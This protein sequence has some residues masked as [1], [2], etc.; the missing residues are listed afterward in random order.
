MNQELEA[1]RQ[2][3]H[4]MMSALENHSYTNEEGRAQLEAGIQACIKEE[5]AI[6]EKY[7]VQKQEEKQVQEEARKDFNVHNMTVNEEKV[8]QAHYR[9]V[10]ELERKMRKA[11]EVIKKYEENPNEKDRHDY[12]VALN[13]KATLSSALADLKRLNPQEIIVDAKRKKQAYLEA[14]KRYEQLSSI[15]K[16]KLK[17]QGQTLPEWNKLEE[18]ANITAYDIDALYQDEGKAR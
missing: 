4:A 11:D 8:M 7:D 18:N 16:L 13:T 5:E 17:V 12:T 10:I 14:K 15:Q 3:K 6:K 1:V 2:K 9:K